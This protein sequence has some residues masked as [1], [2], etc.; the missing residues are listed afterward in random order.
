MEA[1]YGYPDKECYR[2]SSYVACEIL[3][4]MPGENV[5]LVVGSMVAGKISCPHSW[6][7]SSG[8]TI[9]IT[10]DQ[11]NPLSADPFPKVLILPSGLGPHKAIRR[12]IIRI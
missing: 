12:R 2:W 5:C 1:V 10:A 6:V 8:W 9:D 3:E 7:E 4:K 11:F